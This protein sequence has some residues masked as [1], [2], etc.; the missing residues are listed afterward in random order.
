MFFTS[1]QTDFQISSNDYKTSHRTVVLPGLVNIQ[2]FIPDL[3]MGDSNKSFESVSRA[4]VAGGFTLMCN[5]PVGH[6]ESVHD[7]K[8]MA[9][10]QSNCKSSAYCD[11]AILLAASPSGAYDSLAVQDSAGL[12]VGF[13][14]SFS[15]HI[16][17]IGE[18]SAN[19]KAWPESMPIV[20]NA[21][22]SDLA[23]VLLLAN[24][25]G[26][27]VHVTN[28]VT[29][30]DIEFIA[31]NKEKGSRVTCDVS[32]YNLFLTKQSHPSASAYLGSS[33]DV[34]ALWDNLAHID[35]F[36]VGTVPYNTFMAA[37]DSSSKSGEGKQALSIGFNKY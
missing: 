30:E 12:Y 22:Q 14:K 34:K 33:D 35:C 1:R 2:A 18:L 26:R 37:S 17:N 19:F 10:A 8:T 24:L 21:K 3:L 25:Y 6:K 13:D 36:S 23:S 20:A 7:A 32:V 5:M 16:S 4:A 15:S 29:R 9:L 31:L 11:Y 28:V 27:A